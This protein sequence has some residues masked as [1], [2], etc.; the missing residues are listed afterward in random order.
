MCFSPP[1]PKAVNNGP[2]ISL[3][4]VS[5]ESKNTLGAFPEGLATEM[6]RMNSPLW[7]AFQM[8]MSITP[9]YCYKLRPEEKAVL[10]MDQDWIPGLP[11]IFRHLWQV[12]RGPF[13]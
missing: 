1:F 9:I 7:K 3:G 11:G 4:C 6:D 10:Q 12:S 5:V 8:G 2:L 13:S